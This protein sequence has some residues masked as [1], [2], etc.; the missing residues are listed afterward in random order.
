M[1]GA[2]FSAIGGYL[3]AKYSA[4]KEMGQRGKLPSLKF[5]V[6][7]YTLH[8]HHWLYA[9]AIIVAFPAEMGAHITVLFF[10]IGVIAQGLTYRDFYRIVYRHTDGQ[11]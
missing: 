9:S 4:G 10:F 1:F 3:I 5:K 6:N 7:D 2:A 11:A 8:L